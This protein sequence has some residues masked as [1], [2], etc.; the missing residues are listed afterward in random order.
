[1]FGRESFAY[2]SK[3]N[4]LRVTKTNTYNFDFHSTACT[5]AISQHVISHIRIYDAW[6]IPKSNEPT[7][8]KAY[9]AYSALYIKI[10]MCVLCVFGSI[11][12]RI[13]CA[14]WVRYMQ[15]T[16]CACIVKGIIFGIQ[17]RLCVYRIGIGTWYLSILQ[18]ENSNNNQQEKSAG[19]EK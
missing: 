3:I 9:W 1:M 13:K 17:M 11:S 10:Q 6:H 16:L 8:S 15:C 14:M 7:I 12:A 2:C 19:N 5:P 18:T 4:S